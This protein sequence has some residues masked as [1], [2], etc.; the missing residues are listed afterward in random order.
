MIKEN[1]QEASKIL[2]EH[3]LNKTG[4]SSLKYLEPKTINDA[5]EIQENLNED[6]KLEY[7]TSKQEKAAVNIKPPKK[8]KKKGKGFIRKI[9]E[10]LT[11]EEDKSKNKKETKSKSNQRKRKQ[12][13]KPRANKKP[14]PRTANQRN[15][16]AENSKDT[17]KKGNEKKAAQTKGKKEEKKNSFLLRSRGSRAREPRLEMFSIGYE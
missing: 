8:P 14:H 6:T 1:I 4:L 7:K 3:R 13:N 11:G 2:F 10:T 15:K 16:K 17:K 9:I 12:T 5:Y